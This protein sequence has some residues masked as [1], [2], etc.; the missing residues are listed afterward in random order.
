M[1][2]KIGLFIRVPK[3][4]STS[5]INSFSDQGTRIKAGELKELESLYDE[6]Q[7]GVLYSKTG[8]SSPAFKSH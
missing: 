8:A 4:A 5:I 3:N 1:N 2:K 6:N 7:S